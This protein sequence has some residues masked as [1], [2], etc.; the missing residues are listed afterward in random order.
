MDLDVVDLERFT[1][2]LPFREVPARNMHRELPDFT[3][4]EIF[5]VSLKGGAVGT[6]EALHFYYPWGETT[7]E[8]VERVMGRN[9]HEVMWDDSIG[10]GLQMALF[11]AVG[12]T[13]E[14]P[15]HA[16]LGEKVRDRA[17][18]SWWAIDMP[19]EDWASECR[20]ALELGYR[21]FKAKGRPWQDV[22]AQLDALHEIV[23]DD[24]NIDMDFNSTLLDP[25]HA[26]PIL[27]RL[28][29]TYGNLVI[30][31]GPIDGIE[32]NRQ[33]QQAVELPIVHHA[34][35][36]GTQ[37]LDDCCDGYVLGGGASE[38]LQKGIV[39]AAFDKP[40]W[41]QMAGSDI[42]AAFSMHFAAVQSHANWPAV[43]THQLYARNLLATP[44]EVSGGTAAIPDGPGLGVEIDE[45]ALAELRI[46]E[47]YEGFDPPRMIEVAW[48]NGAKF[49]YSTGNQ[50]WRDAQAGNMPCFIANVKT[51]VV[52]D[53][54]SARWRDLHERALAA[55]VREGDANA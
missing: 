24:F 7:D 51:A 42:T 6:G 26:I 55:P 34:D 2:D 10:Y 18:L 21:D 1:I 30:W 36:L 46:S 37:I 43:N 31:E 16:L 35:S 54:G 32:E 22:Y 17:K 19:A 28:E 38:V 14:V 4:F 11:D 41:L 8:A 49:Y 15:V 47:P 9:A 48:P 3:F 44:I 53:D 52:A 39:L 45:D 5:R 27:Q 40:F 50:L 23:P 12:K 13:L 29:K 25:E 33:L 20:E